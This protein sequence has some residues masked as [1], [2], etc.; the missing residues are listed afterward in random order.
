M[1]N[2]QPFFCKPKSTYRLHSFCRKDTA[3]ITKRLQLCLPTNVEASE[4]LNSFY[5]FAR[6]LGTSKG[7]KN[8]L[9]CFAVQQRQIEPDYSQLSS[10]KWSQVHKYNGITNICLN[11]ILCYYNML[12]SADRSIQAVTFE[13]HLTYHLYFSRLK[14]TGTTTVE[15]SKRIYVTGCREFFSYQVKWIINRVRC[16]DRPF[17]WFWWKI[18]IFLYI[19]D[20][21]Y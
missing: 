6:I 13:T 11:D 3:S 17:S 4:V 19:I 7:G 2:N 20:G 12:S 15:R 14:L 18:S 10:W 21:F 16:I 5:S 1:E 8:N 9:T